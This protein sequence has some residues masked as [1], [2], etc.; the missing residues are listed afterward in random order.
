[1]SS[2]L[3]EQNERLERR[4]RIQIQGYDFDKTVNRVAMIFEF[5]PEEVLDKV[6]QRM[7]VKARSVLRYWA[8][9]ELEMTGAAVGR[10]LKM[11]KSVVSRA[12]A[13]G[14]KIVSDMKLK[15]FED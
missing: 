8:V 13:R 14:E 1:V 12:V 4:Y 9:N 10:R 11:S 15:L 5:K 7:R 6:K 3:E 2:V